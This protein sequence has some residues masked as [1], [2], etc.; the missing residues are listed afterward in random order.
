[1]INESVILLLPG[2]TFNYNLFILRLLNYRGPSLNLGWPV[3]QTQRR[4]DFIK[5]S[6]FGVITSLG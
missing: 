3:S 1:M 6:C 4:E 2:L 5:P